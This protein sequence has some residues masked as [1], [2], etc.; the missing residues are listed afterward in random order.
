MYPKKRTRAPMSRIGP[1]SQTSNFPIVFN[2]VF[3][4]IWKKF[5]MMKE[6][7][8][9]MWCQHHEKMLNYHLEQS[10]WAIHDSLIESALLLLA[11]SCVSMEVIFLEV[12]H[13]VSNSQRVAQG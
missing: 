2:K 9:I 10:R 8:I 12:S 11:F 1:T 5:W 3:G 6:M 7:Y 4:F 13:G